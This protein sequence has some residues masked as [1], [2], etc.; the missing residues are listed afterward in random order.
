M[1]IEKYLKSV[2]D[3]YKKNIQIENSK[4][5]E[6]IFLTLKSWAGETLESITIIGSHSK[7]TTSSISTDID[8]LLIHNSKTC[9]DLK[10][11]YKNLLEF[12]DSKRYHP[13]EKN[14]SIG[15]MH[16]KHSIDVFPALKS[17]S[18]TN[19]IKIFNKLANSCIETNIFK[20]IELVKSSSLTQN[21]IL[22]KIWR[23]LNR[24]HFPTFYLELCVLNILQRQKKNPIDKNFLAI[25]DFFSDDFIDETITDPA[26]SKNVISDFLSYENKME[27]VKCASKSRKMASWEEIIW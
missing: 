5:L 25:L 2:I 4:T 24:L 16:K 26:N 23:D 11:L 8:I 22:T 12:L 13:F 6:E 27:I 10:N 3:K 20:H 9:F 19:N 14:H 17:T 7:G 15:F 21:I 1:N 18:D